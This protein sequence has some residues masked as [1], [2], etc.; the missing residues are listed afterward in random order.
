M[1]QGLQTEQRGK[2][3]NMQK[4]HTDEARSSSFK[5]FARPKSPAWT[6][7]SKIT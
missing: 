2:K 7:D 1:T 3:G 4:H 5:V 6:P